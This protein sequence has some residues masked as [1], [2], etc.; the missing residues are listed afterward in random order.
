M[1]CWGSPY[2]WF[3]KYLL[4][5]FIKNTTASRTYSFGSIWVVQWTCIN[6]IKLF[7]F[8]FQSIWKYK[9]FL[10][11][12]KLPTNNTKIVHV[13]ST[14]QMSCSIRLYRG[15]VFHHCRATVAW[16]RR[17]RARFPTLTSRR[18]WVS[19][20][21]SRKFSTF[22]CHDGIIA[23]TQGLRRIVRQLRCTPSPRGGA[24][25]AT[26]PKFWNRKL[27]SKKICMNTFCLCFIF[28]L[29]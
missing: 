18:F 21:L 2:H 20:T 10:L 15:Q 23:V 28:K 1:I 8:Y 6:T 27:N 16:W 13:N 5:N 4:V 9:F 29:P 7:I 19:E 14:W 26:K 25:V 17:L 11:W 24:L 3:R 12:N 22:S